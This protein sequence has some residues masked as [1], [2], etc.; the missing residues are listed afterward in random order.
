MLVSSSTEHVMRDEQRS[1]NIKSGHSGKR[2]RKE[3]ACQY[4][5]HPKI[6]VAPSS[7]EVHGW[8]CSSCSPAHVVT[9]RLKLSPTTPSPVFA[10]VPRD[11]VPQAGG[12]R[13]AGITRFPIQ[14][15][16]LSFCSRGRRG[17]GPGKPEQGPPCREGGRM[18]FDPTE[19]GKQLRVSFG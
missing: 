5:H 9:M 15:S 10:A 7:C 13:G 6:P 17:A 18:G 1:V 8:Y 19:R 16:R 11:V 12:W 2:G 4:V 3:A 14:W